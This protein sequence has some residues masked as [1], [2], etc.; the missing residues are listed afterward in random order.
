VAALGDRTQ[1]G[2]S[3]RLTFVLA[4]TC[5]AT[6]ANLYYGQPLLDEIG[7][8]FGV[9]SGLG[10]I[11]TATQAGFAAGLLLVLP[12][13]DLVDR[14][15]LVPGGI[16]VAAVV[17]A[18]IA[19]APSYPALLAGLLVLGLCCVVAQ[20][21]VPM[22]A[23][24][25]ADRERGRVVGA[26][27]SGLLAGIL[28]ARV[29]SGLVASAAGWRTVYACAAVLMLLLS[30]A[31]ARSLPHVPPSAPEGYV[32]LLRS[33]VAIAGQEPLVVRRGIYGGLGFAAFSAFW[34]SA[35]LL[36]AGPHY[37]YDAAVIGLFSLF[38]VAG[39]LMANVAGRLADR[40][41]A[42]PAR[43]AM[44]LIM[45]ASFGLLA[46][47]ETRLAA[48]IAGVVLLDLA[49]QGAHIL[50]QGEIYALRPEARSRVTSVYMTLYFAGGALGSALSAVL[51]DAGGWRAVCALGAGAAALGLLVWAGE[52]RMT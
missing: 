48:F 43:L 34:T 8:T 51:W 49:V 15:R 18:A 46:L 52:R 47:G 3:R 22:A 20:A 7:R 39:M 37:G 27:M 33:T 5:G 4:L 40:G 30:A 24:I 31:L 36:L 1:A 23:T 19:A 21:L 50:N 41:R 2:I 16:L 11:T 13:G 6:I 26:V 25:A 38:G 12:A 35:A 28:L 9:T 32:A 42:R 29:V 17:L 44:F 45:L 14:R 10:L